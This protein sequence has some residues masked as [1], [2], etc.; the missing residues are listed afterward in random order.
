MYE[1]FDT[2]KNQKRI[3]P[4]L[5]F[6]FVVE[7]EGIQSGAFMEVTGLSVETSVK[8]FTEGGVNDIEYKLPERTKQT[9]LVLK[10]GLADYELWKW[11]EKIINGILVPKNGSI[12]LKAQG[13]LPGMRWDFEKAFPIKWEGPALNASSTNLVATESIVLVH[14]GLKRQM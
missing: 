11:Y 12:I 9:N 2:I 8:T 3:D 13:K 6:G 14:H 5:A 10:R 7:I 4:Y 1:L